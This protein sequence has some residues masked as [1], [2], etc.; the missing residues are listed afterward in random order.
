[1]PLSTRRIGDIIEERATADEERRSLLAQMRGILDRADREKRDLTAAER[2]NYDSREQEVHQLEQ[3]IERCTREEAADEQRS[4]P[5]AH[6]VGDRSTMTTTTSV[7]GVR[8]EVLGAEQRVADWVAARPHEIGLEPQEIRDFPL[9]RAVR[10]MVSG[11]WDGAEIERRALA[12]G[13]DS[14]GGF[15]TPEILSGRMID[16]I[17]NKARVLQAG[18][19]TIPLDSD[20]QSIP[21]M[22]AGVSGAW[23]KENEAVA[24]D[25][26]E[27]ERVTFKPKTLAVLVKISMELF[28]DMLPQSAAAIEQDIA[29]ALALE[30]DRVAL[31]GS[32]TD[33]EPKGVLNQTGVQKVNYNKTPEDWDVLSDAVGALLEDNVEP[34]AAIYAARTAKT[35]GKLTDTTGQPLRRPALLDGVTDLVSNQVPTNVKVGE[36]KELSEIYVAEWPNLMI[37]VRPQIGVRVKQLDQTFADKMQVGLLAWLRA[38]IQLAHP[39]AFHVTE[40]VKG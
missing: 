20:Q 22:S 11:Q 39:E 32:G 18:A 10:G 25:Q 31:R 34:N 27:F 23:R 2:D 21:R 26:P 4:G 36:T 33:P 30:L 28:E 40:Q 7:R 8:G 3:T 19:Q 14:T 13:V 15:L 16:R 1:M 5:P 9:G 24:E 38:D 12:E 17:R 29:I 35:F 6:V 37:G